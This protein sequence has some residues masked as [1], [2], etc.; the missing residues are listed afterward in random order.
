MSTLV[1]V[2]GIIVFTAGFEVVPILFICSFVLEW[3]GGIK[4]FLLVCM[5]L[6][7]GIVGKVV[8]DYVDKEDK[9]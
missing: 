7:L 5:L 3:Y 1:T 8:T 9:S 6:H 2:I 4:L